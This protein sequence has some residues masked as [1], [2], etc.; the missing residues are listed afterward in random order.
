MLLRRAEYTR[1]RSP[2]KTGQIHD[3]NEVYGHAPG[4]ALAAAVH[5]AIVGYWPLALKLSQDFEMKVVY[6]TSRIS[7]LI[8]GQLGIGLNGPATKQRGMVDVM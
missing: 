7:R 1:R 8:N 4:E 3:A 5:E 6:R 2:D